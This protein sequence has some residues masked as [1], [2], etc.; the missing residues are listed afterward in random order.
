VPES[1]CIFPDEMSHHSEEEYSEE[2][3]ERE[4]HQ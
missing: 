1:D 2:E 3:A 4:G